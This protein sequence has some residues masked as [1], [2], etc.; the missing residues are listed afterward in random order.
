VL[1][2]GRLIA[3]AKASLDHGTFTTMVE[4]ALPFGPRTAQRLMAIAAD[5]QIATHVSALPSSWGTLYE[6]TKLDDKQFE[7]CIKDGTIMSE[8]ERRD[9]SAVVKKSNRATREADLG[10]KQLALPKKQFGVIYADPP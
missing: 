2:T 1:E 8:M 5:S 3:E 7:S 6:L 10:A 4:S 9:I